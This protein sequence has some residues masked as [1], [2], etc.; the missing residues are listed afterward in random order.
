MEKDVLNEK[1]INV[2]N[3]FNDHKNSCKDNVK[4]IKGWIKD[5]EIKVE[6]GEKMSSENLQTL[7][8][9]IGK[10]KGEMLKMVIAVLVWATVLF[11]GGVI[12]LV[13]YIFNMKVS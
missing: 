8:T 13:I 3:N 10:V 4:E 5:L 7:M 9:A 1:I 6:E 11:G 12:S 2:E